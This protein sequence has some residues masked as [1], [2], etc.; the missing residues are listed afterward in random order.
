M[1]ERNGSQYKDLLNR[2]NSMVMAAQRTQERLNA[3]VAENAVLRADRDR[4][5]AELA[6]SKNN[7]QLLGD[8]YNGRYKATNEHI[9]A[10]REKLKAHGIDP[11]VG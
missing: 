9:K 4:L 7:A 6:A 10:L 8:D 1:S 11:E 5:S 2:Y 3:V